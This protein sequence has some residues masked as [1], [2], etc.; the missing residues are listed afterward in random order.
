V[1]VKLRR[2]RM[3]GS[4][5]LALS[6]IAP[7]G[8]LQAAAMGQNDLAPSSDSTVVSSEIVS[9]PRGPAPGPVDAGVYR[10]GPGDVLQLNFSGRVSRA[11]PFSVGPEGTAFIPGWGLFK[12]GGLTL[13]EAR[14]VVDRNVR[15]Q[16]RGVSVDLSLVRVRTMRIYATG[17]LRA[18][19]A[20]DVIATSRVTDALPDSD[21]APG[22]SRRNVEVRHA[23]GSIEVADLERFLRTGGLVDN[24]YL[25]DGDVVHVGMASRFVEVQG[26]VA[27]PGRFELGPRDSLST[28][29]ALAGG[30][31][32]SARRDGALVVRWTSPSVSETLRCRVDDLERGAPSVP[33]RDGDRLYL[34]FIPDFH[35]MEQ[36]TIMGEVRAPGTYPLAT[37]QTR[38]SDLVKSC[39]GFSPRA[40]LSTIHLYRVPPEAVDGDP[41]LERLSRLSRTEMTGAEYE[42]L[43]TRLTEKRGDFRIDW[44][45]LKDSP[46]LDIVLTGG[47]VVQVDPIRAS[48]RVEGEVRRPGL[49][50]YDANLG[51]AAYVQLAG[52]FSNRAATN[53]VLVTRR[54]TGQTLRAH[55]VEH[56]APGDMIW[57]P[58][59]PETTVWQS[60]QTLLLVAA[61]VAT[62]VIAVRR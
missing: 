47:D 59:K 39:G 19:G 16:L 24:P 20:V 56:V 6:I 14:S 34:Y 18:P 55:D 38:L 44:N 5:V 17:A 36:A 58:E 54:L 50:Q 8:R 33:A 1:S 9:G 26:A 21:L 32:P 25:R 60:V 53:K 48:V 27:Q 62:V 57:V 61:Q 52:G 31:L 12:L 42:V 43:R 28:L 2:I 4:A 29:L 37:G 3:F 7:A 41:E 51:A 13:V 40:D 45:R 23:D 15:T 49:V 30:A 46:E 35:V 22:A 10:V 11:I